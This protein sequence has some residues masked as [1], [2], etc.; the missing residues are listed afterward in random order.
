MT[1]TPQNPSPATMI[2][3]PG[4]WLGAWAWD[5]VRQ[6]LTAAGARAIALT[7]P[8]L[9]VQDPQRATR[10][11]DD[12]AAAIQDVIDSIDGEVVLVGHSGA[13]GP[14][15]LVLDRIPNRVRR[16]V[17]IDSGPMPPGGAFAPDLPEA[18]EELPLPE[19]DVLGRQASLEGLDI[20]HLD[21][22]REKAVAEPGP[23]ARARIELSNDARRSVPTTLVCCSLPSA[24]VQELAA[25]GHPMFAEVDRL[26]HVELIDLPTGHWPM[27]SRPEALAE[28]IH[29]AA[30]PRP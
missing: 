10:T 5:E 3:V 19:F 11:L 4:Y 1:S 26:E 28:A 16:V 22:F 23:V 29:H 6:H 27:W 30:R 14:V 12:Q 20:D 2:L 13:N 7:L 17:W 8:G 21:R 15:S 24:Q 9:D 18:V 25:A